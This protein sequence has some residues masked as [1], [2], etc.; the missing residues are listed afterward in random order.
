MRFCMIEIQNDDSWS[1]GAYWSN[2][3]VALRVDSCCTSVE[4]RRKEPSISSRVSVSCFVTTVEYRL[5][6]YIGFR[7]GFVVELCLIA[8][9]FLVM[10]ILALNMFLGELLTRTVHTTCHEATLS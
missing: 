10:K 9:Y 1:A 2:T 7:V 6:V 4:T 3:Y 8:H 5:L